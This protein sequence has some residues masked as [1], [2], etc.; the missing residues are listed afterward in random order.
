MRI[1]AIALAVA[2]VVAVGGCNRMGAST[3]VGKAP[4]LEFDKP[5]SGEITSRSG[6]NFNDGSHH[7]VYQ[8]KLEDKQL[9]GIKLT[10]AL[11]GSVAVFNNGILVA[12]SNAGYDRADDGSLAFRANGAG[13][14]QVAV[15]A[16]DTDAFGPYRLRA[17]KLVAYDGK[18]IKAG[19]EIADLLVSKS[20]DYTL[21][22]DKAGMY[23]ISLESNAFDTVLK[24][25]GNGARSEN[26]D[27]AESTDSR[28]S[29][30]LEPGSYTLTVRS[31]GE[32]ATGAF[33]LTAKR[34]EMPANLISRDGTTLPASGN[35][36]GMLDGEG[37]RRFVLNLTGPTEI[38]LD[39][40]SSQVDTLLRVNNGDVSLVDDDGGN[41]TNA[42]LEH[43]LAAGRYTVDVSSLSEEAAMFELRIQTRPASAEAAATADAAVEAVDAAVGAD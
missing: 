11:K 10:G 24:L 17:E 35:V 19:G 33:K 32:D 6:I 39:A 14:Y 26:D 25:E 22:V 41:G 15:N 21:Q 29:L 7:Q 36:F 30:P 13:I 31:L 4:P 42:R 8:M 18:P 5:V 23:E 16:D 9:V 28:I 2:T 34:T 27:T 12:N 40:I 38:Q 37:H 3:D 1:T 43:V 20:Q